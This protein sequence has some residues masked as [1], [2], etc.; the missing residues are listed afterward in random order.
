MKELFMKYWNECYLAVCKELPESIFHIHDNQVL[1]Q[2]K[3]YRI[4]EKKEFKIEIQFKDI[5]NNIIFEEDYKRNRFWVNYEKIWLVFQ[6]K[7]GLNYKEIMSLISDWLKN[8]TKLSSLTPITG[9][10]TFE[11]ELKNDTKL[12]SLTHSQR[13]HYS[14]I[15]LKQDTK[16]S[17]LIPA[18]PFANHVIMLNENTKLKPL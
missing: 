6:E 16:F 14:E 1:R 18:S 15:D 10:A 4:L 3:L 2:K 8:D 5:K 9:L 7:Y 13:L 12:S 17:S 11:I